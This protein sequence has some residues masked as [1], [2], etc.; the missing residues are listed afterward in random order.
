[1]IISAA[2]P[3]RWSAHNPF[4]DSTQ[5][6]IIELL[7]EVHLLVIKEVERLNLRIT[8]LETQQR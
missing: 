8:E 7:R 6:K 2:H 4:I 1:L 5:S 3:G